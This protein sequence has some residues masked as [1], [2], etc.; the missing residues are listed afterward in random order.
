MLKNPPD[1]PTLARRAPVKDYFVYL[2]AK[3]SNS[4]WDCV[5]T[6]V[7]RT[8]IPPHAAYPPARHPVDH[9]FKWSKGRVLQ[10]YQIILISEG[11]G[12]FECA[13]M[14]GSQAVEPGTVLLLFPGIWHRYRPSSKTGW[15]EH[16]IECHGPMFDKATGAG[17]IEPNRS[18]VKIGPA[19][20]LAEC[21]ERCHALARAGA[22]ANQEML[23]TLGIHMLS[24]LGHLGDSERGAAKAIDEF[25]QRAHS[26]IALRC[27]EPLDMHALAAELGVGYSHLRHSFTVRVGLSPR[28]HYLNARLQKVQDL[29]LNTSKSIKE[30]S[31][32]LGFES[33]Y[34]LSNQF[35]SHL[36][37]SPKHWRAKAFERTERMASA[38]GG[39]KRR[40]G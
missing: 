40:T 8:C 34:H 11:A 39:P 32:I 21:F 3:Q 7:G 22:M 5:A 9:H 30:I 17:L 13:S 23:S 26:L 2:P 28:R 16:W 29:L 19:S 4:L 12:T 35:K 6:S 18:V 20:D 25:V 24:L 1:R 14:A 15:V 31:E 38:E 27:H 10:R 33:A 37:I 36:G